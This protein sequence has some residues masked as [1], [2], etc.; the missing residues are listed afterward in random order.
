MTFESFSL[1]DLFLL[2]RDGNGNAFEQI[3]LRTEK[4]VYNLALSVTKSREDAEDVT[5]E[6]YLRIW[7]SLNE[8]GVPSSAKYYI[9]KIA[10][11]AAIDL[12]R[13]R[14]KQN[15]AETVKYTDGGELEYEPSDPDPGSRPDEAYYEKVK[16]ETVR[17]CIAALPRPQRELIVMR[18]M[19]GLSY[20]QIAQILGVP[21]GTVKSGIYRARARLRRLILEKNIL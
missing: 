5:Q 10:H 2:A 8:I 15:E 12:L 18:D 16:A 7:R 21:E 6:T 13:S 20:S 17:E 4:Q 14:R 19:N 1:E 3:V 11:N 9:L